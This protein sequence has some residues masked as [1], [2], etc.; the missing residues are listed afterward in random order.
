MQ[1]SATE[2]FQPLFPG[3]RDV[4]PASLMSVEGVAQPFTPSSDASLPPLLE[5]QP[6]VPFPEQKKADAVRP[7]WLPAGYK[8]GF[9]IQSRDG[10]NLL[11]IQ[12]G[13]QVRYN[14][15]WRDSYASGDRFE[16][17]FTINRVPLVFS[18]NFITPKLGYYILLDPVHTTG[19]VYVEE[20]T[21]SY[22]F[23]DTW[24]VSAGRF[25]NPAFLREI[26]VSFAR[27]LCVER[28]YLTAIFG[29]GVVDGVLLT[30]QTDFSRINLS[31]NDGRNSGATS[32][33][34]DFMDD[35][36]DI[37]VTV[38]ADFKLF[39]DW[40][41]YGDFTSW[42]DQDWGL[43]LGTGLHWEEG[44]TGDDIP[45]HNNNNFVAWTIDATLE[46]HGFSLFVAGVGRHTTDQQNTIGREAVNQYGLLAQCGYQIVPEKWEPYVRYEYI[47]FDHITG[48]GGT[49]IPNTNLNLITLGVNRYFARHAAKIT[50]EAIY[51]ANP[52]PVTVSKM[53]LLED[54]RAGEVVLRSQLQLFF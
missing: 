33:S 3:L 36:T 13:I 45:L 42:P 52:V 16:G 43:F 31:V 50:V 47:D 12:G 15:N 17:G 20:V 7:E 6:P 54:P 38:G 39:G 23:D 26:D 8:S 1:S 32:G 9:T 35:S 11:R 41:Q 49:I 30:R 19:N 37:A 29:I 5:Q 14:A 24:M 53:G 2:D 51:A 27:Q 40:A 46:G 21:G 4:Q 34:T 25:R 22:A 18:G 10:N 48:I 28:S 44:E